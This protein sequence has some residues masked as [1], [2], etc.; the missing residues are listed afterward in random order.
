MQEP[1]IK[2][3]IGAYVSG[4]VKNSFYGL[5]SKIGSLSSSLYKLKKTSSDFESYKKLSEDTKSLSSKI[6]ESTQKVEESKARLSG[7]AKVSTQQKAKLN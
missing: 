1:Q 2:I 3:G 6:A 4:S 7:L 5:E